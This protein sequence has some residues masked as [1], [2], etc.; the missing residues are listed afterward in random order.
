MDVL[1]RRV[2]LAI[3]FLL[4]FLIGVPLC[5]LFIVLRATLLAMLLDPWYSDDFDKVLREEWRRFL[6]RWRGKQ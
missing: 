5:W 3:F 2:P 1:R 6:F 4:V